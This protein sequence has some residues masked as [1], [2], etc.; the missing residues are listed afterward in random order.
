[1]IG[2]HVL[3]RMVVERDGVELP[4]P[5]G[6]RA[7]SLLAYLALHR[8]P[9]PRGELAARLWPD[10]L[11]SSARASLRS[12]VW[13][14]RR[15]LGP[16]AA[17]VIADRDHLGLA[18]EPEVWVDALAFDSLVKAGREQE[19]VALSRGELLA[20]ADDDWVLSARDA[21][22]DRLMQVL[23][24]LA[25]NRESA[26][27]QVGAVEWT[28]A[29]IAAD[30]LGEEA[31]RRL[32]SRLAGS[33]DRGAAL[34]VYRTF[35]ER[36]RRELAVA[37]SKMTRELVERL[38]GEPMTELSVA[39]QVPN[40]PPLIGRSGE[41][42]A[43][44]AVWDGAVAGRGGV[45]TLR[46][47][48]GIGKTRLA[49]EL[50]V[51]A[52]AH[53]ARVASCA[54][55]DL[56][57]AAPLGLWAELIAELLPGL[58]RPPADAAWPDDLARLAP[59]I[60]SQFERP[61]SERP[62][63]PPDLERAR[64]FEAAVALVEW[65]AQD[66]PLMLLIED[67]HIAD[68]SSL[69]LVG[70]VSRRLVGLPVLLV[71]TRRELPRA[72]DAD[73]LEHVLRARGRLLEEV[74]L[75][76]LEPG[77]VAELAR[78]TAGL[79][80]SDIARVVEAAEG[81]ALLAVESARAISR[82]ERELSASLRGAV[83]G[84]F[85]SLS[86]EGRGFAEFAAVAAREVE[87]AELMALPIDDPTRAAT[88]ALESGML[89]ARGHRV[90][91]RHAL[92]RDAVYA[93]LPEPRRAALHER[94]AQTL[95]R[96]DQSGG[97]RRA[98][99]IA[100]HLR[101]AGRD[102]AAVDQLARA[103]GD[104]R[105]VAALPEAAE[106]LGEALSMAP[107]RADLLLELGDVQAWRALRPEAEAAFERALEFM[108][109]AS[110]L[111]LARA[112]LRRARWYHGS[113]CVPALVRDSCAEALRLLDTA[114]DAAVSERREAL[115]GLA[116]AQATAGSVEGAERLLT[117]LHVLTVGAPVDD[118]STYDIGHARALAA[119]RKGSFEDAYGPSIA[120]GE[121]AARAGRPDLAYGCW[122]NAAGAAAAAGD[123]DR[124][125]AFVDRGAAALAHR[126]LAILELHLLAA[127][128]FI[129]LRLGGLAEARAAAESMTGVAERLGDPE[130]LA[131]A[132]H[133]RGLVAL[134]GNDFAAAADLLAAA[135]AGGATISRPLTHLARAEALARA[136]RLDEARAELRET[137]LG[138]V[139]PSD[140]PE[141]LV[142]RL[143]RVQGLIAAH[144][145]DRELALRRFQEAVDG[146]RGQVSRLTRG[147]SMAAVLTDLGR[148]VVGLIEPERELDRVA[149]E[150]ETL[151]ASEQGVRHAVVS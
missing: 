79:R 69:E 28:R 13:S 142:P 52:S 140:F 118:F 67:I 143:A 53:G 29:Q 98:A 106:Y 62:S 10:V 51:H 92:L 14:L 61:V 89:V 23:E 88:G 109:G 68:A 151:K 17:Q 12:A 129:W 75:G 101:L 2:V 128:S 85:G 110:V 16:A 34:V 116:W 64:L 131:M 111:E 49:D 90:G 38:R 119:M 15:V 102:A 141:T 107:D 55:L 41:L 103:A 3:G 43:L 126:G 25:T 93:D 27:D 134:A 63:A 36:L 80:E 54:A 139:R 18:G 65:M 72:D 58:R 149:L 22:R 108:D 59:G 1:V 20:G 4:A 94:W 117:E 32:I 8:G 148:P 86:P 66:R 45:V 47:E 26:G 5:A 104:A 83:R 144:A 121:A 123:Y 145:G 50:R 70:Y 87:R 114:G 31:H 91:F 71:L 100:R 146:W 39:P 120:A 9:Q 7:W 24:R 112:W 125:L 35:A 11:D 115:A 138:P 99:E 82:G 136:G 19:A 44:R 46:G 42:A 21:H 97:I 96:C 84:A 56:G 105:R 132:A 37:P 60:Q 122:A 95:L 6:R 33:G 57:G 74:V 113:I 135:L 133:D 77:F 127:R 137:V 124:A 147:D 76:P 78:G 81:N 73:R 48:A 40:L 30:P 130:L 150:L